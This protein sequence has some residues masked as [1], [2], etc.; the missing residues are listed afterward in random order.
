M[1]VSAPPLFPFAAALIAGGQSR[2]MG[3]DKA[4]L[5]W[6]GQPLWEAQLDKLAAL[7]PA[8][9]LLSCRREQT[10]SAPQVEF[11]YDPPGSDGPLPAL[12]RCLEAVDMPVLALAVDMPRVTAAFLRELIAMSSTAHRGVIYHGTHGYEPLCALYPVT[13]M[14]L[15][16]EAIAQGNFR[17]QN[18]IQNAVE[19]GWL[20]VV[21]M[22]Q[23]KLF[24]N[25]NTPADLTSP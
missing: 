24:S 18:L 12:A 7:Q 11:V 14:P 13:I 23:E 1:P 21:P 16:Q 17:F 6:Q 22:T 20:T 4:F 15:L 9:L 2:R 25:L 10:I 5:D 8:R 3:R 19:A